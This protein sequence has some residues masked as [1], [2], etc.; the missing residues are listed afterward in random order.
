MEQTGGK[1]LSGNVKKK[2][3]VISCDSVEAALC[4][5]IHYKLSFQS[6]VYVIFLFRL[7]ALMVLKKCNKFVMII[8]AKRLFT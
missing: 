6:N 8:Y 2:K 4:I 7:F 1:R 3:D 5:F